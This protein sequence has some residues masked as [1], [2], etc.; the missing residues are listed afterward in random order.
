[1]RNILLKLIFVMRITK[2]EFEEVINEKSFF[3]FFI[4]NLN[5]K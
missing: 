2:Y 4:I 3:E 5:V 1:M